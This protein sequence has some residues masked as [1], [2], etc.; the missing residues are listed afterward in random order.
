[1]KCQSCG[2]ESPAEMGFCGECGCE[3]KIPAD[4][5]GK[6]N[7]LIEEWAGLEPNLPPLG[8]TIR[9]QKNKMKGVS[10]EVTVMF[11]GMKD[12]TRKLTD[13]EKCYIMSYIHHWEGLKS[14]T[15]E[16]GILAVFGAVDEL[17]DATQRAV[18]ASLAIHGDPAEFREKMKH[19]P[20]IPLLRIGIHTGMVT[21]KSVEHYHVQLESGDTIKMAYELEAGAEPG[22]TYVSEETHRLTRGVFSFQRMNGDGTGRIVG[23]GAG[24]A[25]GAAIGAAMGKSA[26]SIV[27]GGL[28]GALAGG[29]IGH[30]AYDKAG[31]RQQTA[32][33]FN[34]HPSQGSLNS[35]KNGK[36][37]P[38][39]E[40]PIPVYKVLS[41]QKD[42]SIYQSCKA[43]ME[44]GDLVQWKEHFSLNPKTWFWLFWRTITFSKMNHS[45]MVLRL[46]E[47][48]QLPTK[49][50]TT[51]SS[52]F[53]GTA[54]NRLSHR[55]KH[56]NGEVWWHPLKDKYEPRRQQIGEE[57][58]ARIGIPYDLFRVFMISLCRWVGYPCKI[59]GIKK[60][61][62]ILERW[63]GRHEQDK[64]FCSE[65][66]FWV[67]EEC[68]R[69]VLD[70]LPSE[71][72]LPSEILRLGIFKDLEEEIE[73][74]KNPKKSG[75]QKIL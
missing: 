30:Y 70:K 67:Y 39:K 40:Q 11:C 62:E 59:F 19:E 22:T 9:A 60:G 5:S 61:A 3:L 52:L 51:E 66:C 42:L 48:E 37:V 18:S 16:N 7:P 54:L 65:Y 15:R 53:T 25:T 47:F 31:D 13:E 58:L 73:K 4:L 10:R 36:K 41:A 17:E 38:G 56:Y 64:V 35:V 50:F 28:L 72:P 34:F 14:P 49:R 6:A 33:S 8:K 75:P 71:L 44:T 23:A 43:R 29:A 26:K 2:F 68:L 74:G 69:N 20:H 57:M 21:I 46:Q 1:M 63:R 12:Q 55:L 24:A 27:I 32:K 45:S